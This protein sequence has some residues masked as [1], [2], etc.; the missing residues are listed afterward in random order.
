MFQNLSAYLKH[1]YLPKCSYIAR[2]AFHG[3][4]CT[5]HLSE[6]NHESLSACVGYSDNFTWKS[7]NGT[8]EGNVTLV[9]DM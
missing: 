2:G 5:V 4:T 1:V 3:L 7:Y 8:P 6:A 9:Y